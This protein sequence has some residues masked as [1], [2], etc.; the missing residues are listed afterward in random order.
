MSKAAECNG[1][2]DLKC[3]ICQCDDSHSGRLCECD[4]NTAGL[5]DYEALCRADNTTDVLCNDRGQC[6]CGVCECFDR[7]K[8]NEVRHNGHCINVITIIIVLRFMLTGSQRSV[9]RV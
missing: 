1:G 2:G 8:P 9:L 4:S 5:G 3:G 7:E 6:N